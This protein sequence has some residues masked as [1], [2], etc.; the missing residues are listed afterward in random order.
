MMNKSAKT[1][2]RWS[3]DGKIDC[4]TEQY[5]GWRLFSLDV[6]NM[7]RGMDGLGKLAL[8]DA[9]EIHFQYYANKDEL[10]NNAQEERKNARRW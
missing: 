9:D 6:I 4:K 7:V 5:T 10:R 3:D 1:L 2:R 8:R